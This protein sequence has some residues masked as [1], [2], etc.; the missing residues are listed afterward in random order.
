[1]V[2]RVGES[3]RELPE[4]GAEAGRRPLS[5]PRQVILAEEKQRER[6]EE[7][8]DRRRQKRRLPAARGDPEAAGDEGRD[9]QDSGDR[10]GVSERGAEAR[11]AAGASSGSIA[12]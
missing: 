11:E 1:M 12:L 3:P 10:P 8:E 7:E 2:L 4:G 5:G 9:E 6:K